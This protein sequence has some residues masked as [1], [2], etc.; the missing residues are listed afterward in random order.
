M[1]RRYTDEERSTLVGLVTERRATVAEAARQ[2][3]VTGSTAYHWMKRA[4]EAP[5]ERRNRAGAAPAFVQVVRATEL[6]VTM[7][8]RV[9]R[10]EVQ[11][12]RGFDAELLRAVVEALGGD[13]A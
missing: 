9:G 8:V 7:A 12:G 6:G 5:K 11:V 2:L 3:G 1:R 13:E 4:A 10:A